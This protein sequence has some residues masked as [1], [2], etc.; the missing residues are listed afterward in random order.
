MGLL[1][2]FSNLHRLRLLK[3]LRELVLGRPTVEATRALASEEAW[4]SWAD[5]SAA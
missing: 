4:R 5:H 1:Y 3:M 2:V